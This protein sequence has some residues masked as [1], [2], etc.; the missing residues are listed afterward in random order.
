[1]ETNYRYPVKAEGQF[2]TPQPTSQQSAGAAH[3]RTYQGKLM[4]L[5]MQY[6]SY[7]R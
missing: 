7:H 6:R 3:Q 2:D 5:G 1:M 4:I